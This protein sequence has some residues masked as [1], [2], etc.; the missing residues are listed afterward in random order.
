MKRRT[1]INGLFTNEDAI[2]RLIDPILLEQTMKGRSSASAT[3]P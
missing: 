1:E 2:I 3:R